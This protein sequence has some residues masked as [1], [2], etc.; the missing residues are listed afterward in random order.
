MQKITPFL[1]FDSEAEEAAD[2]YTSIFRN[3]R[4][5]SVAHYSEEGAK[6]SGREKGSVMTVEFEIEGQKFVALNG[7]P[8]FSFTPAISFVVSCKTQAEIDTLW[9][10][11]AKEGEEWPCGWLKDKYGVAWQ[12]VPSDLNRLLQGSTSE[13]VTRELIKMKKIDVSKLRD[14]YGEG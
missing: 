11:L 2:F 1:W 12:I 8:E 9:E 14:A 10:K 4:I 7:G 13:E 3:S 6:A 5:V